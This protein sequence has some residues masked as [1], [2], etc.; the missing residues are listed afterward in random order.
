MKRYVR[1]RNNHQPLE[2]DLTGG[3]VRLGDIVIRYPI[4]FT[5]TDGKKPRPMRGKVV[6]IHP[7]GRYHVVRFGLG[8]SAV[9]ESF[10]GT[11]RI[12]VLC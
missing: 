6:Y 9:R 8:T 2:G 4:T 1:K 5:D 7:K 10:L 11:D 12:E 3:H